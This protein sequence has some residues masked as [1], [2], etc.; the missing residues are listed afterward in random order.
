MHNSLKQKKGLK[1]KVCSWVSC[2]RPIV[3]PFPSSPL[4]AHLREEDP[5]H[6]VEQQPGEEQRGD[7]EARQ[8]DKGYERHTE[9]HPHEVHQGP[10]TCQDPDTHH[11]DGDSD[12]EDFCQ[13]ESA[14]DPE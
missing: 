4:P 7:L 14:A 10:V 2:Q 12:G 5:E 6:V 1:V 3:T 9:S 13:G 8:S 11:A